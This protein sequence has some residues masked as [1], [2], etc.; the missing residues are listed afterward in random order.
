MISSS[1]SSIITV[2]IGLFQNGVLEEV[3]SYCYTLILV[4]F[5]ENNFC[6]IL[7][8]IRVQYEN[9]HRKWGATLHF[10]TVP[11]CHT[12]GLP[13]FIHRHKHISCSERKHWVYLRL[14][15]ISFNFMPICLYEIHMSLWVHYITILCPPLLNFWTKP[16]HFKIW[17]EYY[18]TPL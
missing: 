15:W 3:T 18:V 10:V 17:H 5:T 16:A 13:V 6:D 4:V 9:H 8:D 7:T 14:L 12:Y 2:R 1:Y 11:V